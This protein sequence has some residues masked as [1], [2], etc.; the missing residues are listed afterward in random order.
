MQISLTY[1]LRDSVMISATA[2]SLMYLITTS[3][4][5]CCKYK[6]IRLNVFDSPGTTWTHEYASTMLLEYL[7]DTNN[8]D[9]EKEDINFICDLIKGDKDGY[10]GTESKN[11]NDLKKC[12]RGMD[13]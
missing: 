6:Y 10:K 13:V 5:L 7:V 4:E 2:H 1:P 8:L 3:S 11:I 12:Y 9:M